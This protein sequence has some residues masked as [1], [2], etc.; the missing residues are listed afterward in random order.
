[1]LLGT[2]QKVLGGFDGG[3]LLGAQLRGQL[4]HAQLVEFGLAH[5]SVFLARLLDDLGNQE[6]A[7]FGLRCVLHVG[8]AVIGLTYQIVT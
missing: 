7:V 5:C 2:G 1:M 6:V 3:D 8:V 4:G